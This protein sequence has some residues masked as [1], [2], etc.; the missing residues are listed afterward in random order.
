MTTT[1]EI[2]TL[3]ADLI[4]QESQKD[5]P[6]ITRRG[7]IITVKSGRSQQKTILRLNSRVVSSRSIV[8]K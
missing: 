3:L 5:T 8:H 7:Q 2:V 1:S 4:H 6:T